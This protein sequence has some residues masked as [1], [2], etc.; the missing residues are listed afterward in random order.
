PPDEPERPERHQ[1]HQRR[2]QPER[3]PE[4]LGESSALE[5]A[6][7]DE[8][9]DRRVDLREDDDA[10]DQA[11][12]ADHG[13]QPT[14]GRTCGRGAGSGGAEPAA[15]PPPQARTPRRWPGLPATPAVGKA[16]RMNAGRTAHAAGA[17]T[18]APESATPL[19][20][21]WATR[22]PKPTVAP[23]RNAN[24]RRRPAPI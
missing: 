19:V 11:Q 23:P 14:R 3:K 13:V 18:A 2:Q 7:P 22:L 6:A 10:R 17:R 16:A 5:R 4:H 21:P 24:G 1:H 15:P 12:H 8:G 9:R 20:P